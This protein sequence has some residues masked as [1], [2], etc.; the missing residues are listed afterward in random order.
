M[1]NEEW[2]YEEIVAFY[3]TDAQSTVKNY[4]STVLYKLQI[5]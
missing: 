5:L 4:P 2:G 1:N 3:I